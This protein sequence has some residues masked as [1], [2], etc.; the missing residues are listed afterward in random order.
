MGR[1]MSSSSQWKSR[2]KTAKHMEVEDGDRS[3]GRRI[4]TVI[5]E[6]PTKDVQEEHEWG[7]RATGHFGC[8]LGP[9][10]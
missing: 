4:S 7:R 2:A 5:T 1:V 9:K 3:N 10:S 8:P 6:A